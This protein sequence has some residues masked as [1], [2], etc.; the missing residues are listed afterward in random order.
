MAIKTKICGLK[1]LKTELKKIR[2]NKK[3]KIVFTNG[4]FDILHRGHVE[5]LEASS[6]RGDI[7]VVGLNS[8]TSVRRLKGKGRPIMPYADRSRVV[9]VA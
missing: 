9:A 5:Y 2:R 3:K 7:L 6:L 1:R 8:D 4:C